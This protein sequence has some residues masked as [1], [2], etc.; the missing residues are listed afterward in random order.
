MNERIARRAKTGPELHALDAGEIDAVLDPAT[1]TAHLLPDAQRALMLGGALPLNS[2]L[3]ALPRQDYQRMLPE[4]EPVNLSYGEVLYEPTDRLAHVYF[5]GDAQISLLV[6]L[7]AGKALEVALVG[8]E[9]LVGIPLAFDVEDSPV[10]AR[11]QGSGSAVRMQAGSFREELARCAP[12][13]REVHRYAYAKL[14]QARQTA[15]CNRFHPVEARLA[16]WL[17]LTRDRVRAEQFHL[18]H[19]FLADMLGVRRAGV[20][21]AAA[22]LQRRKLIRYS[23]GDITI[24]DREGLA[25]ASCACY[26]V[27]RKLAR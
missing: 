5:P 10:R 3:A 24:L 4:L 23:R 27:V 2:L 17:L 7:D 12:L 1:Q 16:R 26:E 8:R 20:T 15:V 18:T 22:S 6:V 25:A 9:G 11:V 19:E 14:A 13:Q 21:E